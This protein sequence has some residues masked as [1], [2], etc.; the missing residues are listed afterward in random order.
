M[1][2]QFARTFA[3]LRQRTRSTV[4]KVLLIISMFVG[5]CIALVALVY[6]QGNIFDGVRTYVRGEGLWAK[7]QK[8]AVLYL[9]H[10]SYT[11]NDV[12]FQRYRAATSVMEGDHQARQALL[13]TPI[14]EQA[15]KQ[16]FIQGLND[17]RDTD[18]LIWFF[19]HFQSNAYMRQAIQLWGLADQRFE[20][21]MQL[22][23]NM[24]IEINQLGGR[25]E[26][27]AQYRQQLIDAN[28]ELLSLEIEFSAVLSE[29][30]RWVKQ[31]T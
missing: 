9:T 17:E 26:I 6:I 28:E 23:E 19:R 30:A 11:Q 1:G 12:D 22:A 29:G 20:F 21:V 7:A 5:I 31:M 14:D 27:L 3:R 13:A 24:R 8:D 16:G 10:Y 18:S 25:P 2:T 4:A 15:A